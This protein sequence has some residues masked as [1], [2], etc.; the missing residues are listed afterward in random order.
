MSGRSDARRSIFD[1]AEAHC[2]M[3]TL[4]HTLT[5]DDAQLAKLRTPRDDIV[6]E[7]PEGA[8]HWTLSEG[9]FDHYQ[10][11]LSA[12]PAGDDRWTVTQTYS[13]S[14]AVPVWRR[15]FTPAIRHAI[16]NRRDRY[17]YWW[18]PPDRFDPR[19]ATVL[20]LLCAV[21]IVDGYL[22]TVLTQTL[23]FAADEFHR[24]NTAQGLVLGGVRAGVLIALVTVSIA[25]RRGRKSLLITTGI[26]S[27]AFTVLGGLS[28]GLWMLGASQLVARGLSTALGILIVIVAAEEMPARSR[29]WAASVLVLSAGLGSGMA[30]WILPVADLDV[31]G[32]RVV[33]LVAAIGI[34]VMVSV[35]KRL[36]ES[37]RFERL[38]QHGIDPRNADTESVRERRRRRLILLATSAFL[39][40]M[41][42]APASGFQNDFLKD[43]RGFSAAQI[44]LFTLI[45]STPAG[46]GVLVG[47]YLAETRG[48]RPVG[49]LGIV[50]GTVLAVLSFLSHGFG[51]WLFALGGVVLGGMAVPALAVYGPELFGTHDRGRAN[52]TIVTIG[53]AGSAVGLITAGTLSDSMGGSLAPALALL[54]I[55]PII[56]A[57]LVATLY[58]ETAAT[59]LEDLNPEDN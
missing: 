55:G 56:V 15:L 13:Y 5:C 38:E 30:V 20:G 9:P 58:P 29:A 18:A 57:V 51:L 16:R 1:R 12:Q 44:T 39:L 25:D 7:Q 8:D 23:T 41:F 59:E 35:G 46:I 27:C 26:G 2:S 42:A 47:G 43:E 50:L 22:G 45:T 37:G 14:L 53:V 40:A 19:S 11:Q 36:P 21:Q 28:T 6:G 48:R 3:T 17:G 31:R 24:D 4:Q 49:A 54:A 32:W 52:G 10:R 33:Y 34:L